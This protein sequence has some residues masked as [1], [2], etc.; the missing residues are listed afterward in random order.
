[1]FLL[2]FLRQPLILSPGPLLPLLMPFLPQTCLLWRPLAT[3]H[4]LL[5]LPP[6]P[7]MMALQRLHSLLWQQLLSP[8]LSVVVLRA[9]VLAAQLESLW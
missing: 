2:S 7:E 9:G 3:R 5:M 4:P 8:P 1:V 6:R